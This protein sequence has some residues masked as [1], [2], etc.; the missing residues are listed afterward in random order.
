MAL[1]HLEMRDQVVNQGVK[2]SS[3]PLAT[4]QSPHAYQK[5]K[6]VS[7]LAHNKIPNYVEQ[8]HTNLISRP[9]AEGV[10]LVA[11]EG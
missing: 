6:G 2:L 7:S 3:Q 1:H 8:G 11:R 9:L 5:K 4:R 10:E